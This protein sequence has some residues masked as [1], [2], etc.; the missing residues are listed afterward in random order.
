MVTAA[1]HKIPI[2]LSFPLFMEKK[3]SP[4]LINSQDWSLT[5]RQ[6]RL[7]WWNQTKIHSARILLVGAGGLG[8]NQGKILVQIGL[9]G[10]DFVDPDVAE[11]SNRNRQL[12]R[13][14][15]VGRP[16]AHQVI[17]NLQP[18]ATYRTLLRG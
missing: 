18:Y 4:R 1:R 15:D 9:G 6:Q 16:K 5:D 8:S 14:E 11:D 13:A 12:F 7:S 10:I 3:C 17:E 2:C